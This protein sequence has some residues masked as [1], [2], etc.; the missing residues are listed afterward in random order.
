MAHI[1][2]FKS[3]NPRKTP[4]YIVMDAQETQRYKIL[5]CIFR[6]IRLVVLIVVL[7]VVVVVVVVVVVADAHANRAPIDRT[8]G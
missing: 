2:S 7:A 6:W 5:F 1:T 3:R 4:R 8:P